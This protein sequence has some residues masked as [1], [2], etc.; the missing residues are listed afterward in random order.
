MKL[1]EE[2][3]VLAEEKCSGQKSY[4]GSKQMFELF[5]VCKG[6]L[7]VEETLSRSP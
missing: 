6:F 7:E 5:H 3:K 2:T 1:D 4:Q